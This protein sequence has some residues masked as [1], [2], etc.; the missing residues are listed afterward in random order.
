[1]IL[2]KENETL[3]GLMS[4]IIQTINKH[5]INYWKDNEHPFYENIGPALYAIYGLPHKIGIHNDANVQ[6]L[7]NNSEIEV[8]LI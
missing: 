4:A 8:I 5:K 3:L 7:K 2:D 6:K 1:M